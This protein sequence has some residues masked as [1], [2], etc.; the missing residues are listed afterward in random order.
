MA[1]QDCIR[2]IQEAAGRNLAD[3]EIEELA[4]EIERIRRSRK[5]QGS[6][7]TLE[8]E[9]LNAADEVA[10]EALEAA[11]IEQRNRLINIR[12]EAQLK[13]FAALVDAQSGD[14]SLALEAR[15]VGTNTRIP[16]ARLSVDARGNALFSEYAGGMIADFKQAGVLTQF[17]SRDL[18]RSIARELSELTKLDGEVGIS[19]SDTAAQIAKII[20]KYR[21]AAVARENRAGAW[22]KP[23]EGYITRQSHDMVR[24]RRAGFEVWRDRILPLLDERTFDGADPEKFLKGAFEG[25]STG[26]HLKSNGADETDLRF[27]FNGPA[28]LARRVSEHR[29]LHFRDADAWLDY[30]A[31]F[32]QRSFTESILVELERA[33]RNTA[34][35]EAFGTNPRAMFDKVLGDL[36]DANR[37]DLDK[38]KRLERQRLQWFMD[39]VEGVTRIPVNPTAAHVSATVRNVQSMAKLGGAMLS[40][41]A[42]LPFKASELRFQGRNVLQS[43]A[44]TLVNLVDGFGS[45]DKRRVADLIGVGLD[46]QI[47]DLSSR[48]NSTD[49]IPGR[50]AKLQQIFFKVNL[51]GPWTDSNKRGVGRI[52]ARDLAQQKNAAWNDLNARKRNIL[53]AFGFDE[54]KWSVAQR[55]VREE[56]DGVE[57]LMPDAIRDLPDEAFTSLVQGKATGRK[58]RNVKDELETA[59]RSYYVDR[60]DFAVP[61]PGAKEQAFLKFG[62]RPGTPLGEAVRFMTQ[63]KA[64]PVTAVVKPFSRETFGAGAFNF[65]DALLRGQ[66]DILG[67]VNLIVGTTVMGYVAQ[68]SKEIAKGRSPRDPSSPATWQAAMLQGGGLGIYGD[69]LLGETN[70]FGRSMLDTLAGPTIGAV[71]DIDQIR[72]KAMADEDV[73]A[74]LVRLFKDNTPFLNLFYTRVALD[75]LFL[76]QLQESVNPGF[77]RRMERNIRKENN[78]TFIVP[79]S[80]VI[81]RGGGSRVL[82]SVR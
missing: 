79:P 22:I 74:D 5:A 61:T 20:D 18:E 67:L 1:F 38:F 46:G 60:A 49:N 19:G 15:L 2:E 3:E 9:L 77:L 27:A 76:Y 31:E 11:R 36:K 70:R 33:A 81:P 10:T 39:E 71:S 52:F 73:A 17:N 59:L 16:E 54:A 28:N 47:G 4:E 21:K 50:F 6:L 80:S 58:I 82:E 12:T 51:L 56:A 45:K 24:V 13:S 68:S 41:I 57:Y 26:R 14:P 37:G 65:R 53:E 64:F 63:F 40:A 7:E 78:Q 43:Y 8:E 35:M 25:I 30:N 48:F 72:A 75:Y 44:D 42:D 23:L 32:G 29:I 62:T 55:A 34:L 66:A 69:F